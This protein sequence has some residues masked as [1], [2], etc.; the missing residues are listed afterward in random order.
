MKHLGNQTRRRFTQQYHQL[1]SKLE[2]TKV[3]F[4]KDLAIEAIKQLNLTAQRLFAKH[5]QLN[6][7][8]ASIKAGEKLEAIKEL[9]LDVKKE[10]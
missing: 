7:L 5:D 4:I 2:R 9:P 6:A 10:T 1:F 3:Q 8:E